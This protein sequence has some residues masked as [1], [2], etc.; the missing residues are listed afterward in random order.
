M[1]QQCKHVHS[2][3]VANPS[4]YKLAI[5]ITPRV[6]HTRSH[7]ITKWYGKCLEEEFK[8]KL[9]DLVLHLR[10]TAVRNSNVYYSK[11]RTC[12]W[13]IIEFPQTKLL[14]LPIL[15]IMLFSLKYLHCMAKLSLL[16]KIFESEY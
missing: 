16:V 8:Q 2:S 4:L 3:V 15:C 14:I 7:H 1:H 5:S 9:F 12:F 10:V 11:Q 13:L 6:I